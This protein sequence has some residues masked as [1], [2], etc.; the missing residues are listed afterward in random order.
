[1]NIVDKFSTMLT[2]ARRSLN[3][4]MSEVAKASNVSDSAYS[5]YER[6]RTLPDV[7]IAH[8]VLSVLKLPLLIGDTSVFDFEGVKLALDILNNPDDENEVAWAIDVCH[9][10]LDILL[11]C[12]I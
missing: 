8:D 4:T 2:E 3:L 5:N 1:M 10:A 12:S 6:G 11:R 9:K 7:L